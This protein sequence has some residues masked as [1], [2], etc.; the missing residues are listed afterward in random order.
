METGGR[1]TC[2]GV[3]D[4]CCPAITISVSTKLV[5]R[6]NDLWPECAKT[7][8]HPGE[9]WSLAIREIGPVTSSPRHTL[10]PL[11]HS[12]PLCASKNRMIFVIKYIKYL[13]VQRST[14]RIWLFAF[15]E[16]HFFRHIDCNHARSNEIQSHSS[17]LNILSLPRLLCTSRKQTTLI[18]LH[19]YGFPSHYSPPQ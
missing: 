4:G 16:F 8:G 7:C 19:S 5:G 11:G 9:K 6:F 13:F 10:L 17:S 18:Y 3:E 1:L 14:A 12:V 15:T 2:L